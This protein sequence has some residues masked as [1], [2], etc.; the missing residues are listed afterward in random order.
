MGRLSDANSALIKAKRIVEDYSRKTEL[1]K[2]CLE[3]AKEFGKKVIVMEPVKGGMLANLSEKAEAVLRAANPSCSPAHWALRFVQ[4]ISSVDVCL[5]GMS[6]LSQVQANLCDF[7]P[8]SE[9][10]TLALKKAAAI[11]R[12]LNEELAGGRINKIAQPEP[13]ALL[14]TMMRPFFAA[15]MGWISG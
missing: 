6:T 2:E 12:E 13:D 15:I 9:K 5:S 10:E 7:A 8:L 4:Q 11:V 3:V 14:I 1:S